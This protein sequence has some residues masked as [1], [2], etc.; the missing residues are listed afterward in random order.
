MSIRLNESLSYSQYILI[1]IQ[2][3]FLDQIFSSEKLFILT[4]MINSDIENLTFEIRT[5]EKK[6]GYIKT[7]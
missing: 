7:T 1:E 6:K 3:I 2:C 4:K 5:S